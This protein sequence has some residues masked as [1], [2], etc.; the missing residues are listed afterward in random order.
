MSRRV[1]VVRWGTTIAALTALAALGAQPRSLDP[2]AAQT[3]M[4][5]LV[6]QDQGHVA[7]GLALRRLAVS[8]TLMQ[9]ITHPDD[10][11]NH[12]YAYLTLGQGLR[13]VDV[14]TTRGEGGQNEI[15]PELFRD[16]GVLRT[17]ELMSAHRLDGAEQ[18]FTRAIDY[19]YSFDP[20]EIYRTWNRQEVVRDLVYFMRALRPDVVLTMT[21]QGAGGDRAHESTAVVTQEAF[22]AAGDPTRFPEQIRAGLRPWQPRK[23]YFNGG[24]G[25]IG[26]AGQAAAAPSGRLTMV[27]TSAFDPLL[28]RTYQEIG[29]DARGNHKCQG[30][31]QL[32]PLIGGIGGGRGPVGPARYRLVESVIPGQMDKEETSLFDGVET[33]LMGLAAYAGANP[34]EA[35]RAGLASILEQ[36]RLAQRLFAAGDTGATAA[37]VVAGLTALRTLRAAL[38]SMGLSDEARFEID[39]RLKSKEADYE[40]AALLAHGLA[41]EAL[42]DDGLV[43]AGQPLKLTIAAGNRGAVD[44]NLLGVAISGLEGKTSCAGTSLKAG[45]AFTCNADVTVP[46]NARLT[47]PYWTDEYWDA[48]PPKDALNIFPTDVEFGVPFRPSPF[49]ARFRLSLGGVEVTKDAAI[50][51][52]YPKDIFVGEKRM[53]PNVVPAFS[54]R[55]TPAT[56][57]IPAA[58]AGAAAA[59]R[60]IVVSVT[61]GMKGAAQATVALELPA[62]WTATPSSAPL[63]FANEDESLTIRF[64]VLPPARVR[65]GDYQVK[66][67]VTSA[68][69]GAE[70]GALGYQEI[71]YPHIERRQVIKPAVANLKVIDVRTTPG[72]KIG[73]VVGAGDQVPA[74]LEQLGARVSLIQPDELAWGDLSKYDVIMTGV[75]AYLKRNDLRAYNRRLI[76]FA[77]GGG[78]VIVQYNKTEFNQAQYGPFPAK[79]GNGRVTDEQAAVK[80]LVPNHPVFNVP[81]RITDSA[82][83]GWVQERGLYFLGE[84]DSKYADLISMHDSAPDNPGEK[85]GSLVEA[86]VGAGRWIYLGLGLWRQLP[87]QTEGAYQL[88][89]NLISL[90]RVPSGRAAR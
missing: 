83:R 62:G 52:R 36:A 4:V 74:A 90:R 21:I 45:S 43:V 57:V 80:V 69:A 25:V 15:G 29:T 40:K 84:R 73:Y 12:L 16:I 79:V 44:V 28:G 50:Q 89:A 71:D 30:M 14:H 18:W 7:L 66:A 59:A 61:S 26:G 1:Q 85:L 33:S 42:A 27:D 34:P 58:R 78:T 64:R 8:G 17:A 10:E 39:L 56:A 60:D 41:F 5:S 49:R 13:S 68:V 11:H 70:R 72:V 20:E 47:E 87:A 53:E 81:N 24:S 76:E 54:L 51:Y 6:S 2:L 88:L 86:R 82:W 63:S 67:V 55:T 46:A 37:P 77:E 32:P 48:R 9:S 35:L 3:R 65:A 75:R 31:G 19:G 22:R 23:L 38:P